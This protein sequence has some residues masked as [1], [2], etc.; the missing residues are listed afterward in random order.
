LRDPSILSGIV[1]LVWGRIHSAGR[2]GHPPQGPLPTSGSSLCLATRRVPLHAP[3]FR[4]GEDLCPMLGFW[5]LRIHRRW[6]ELETCGGTSP[7]HA[8]LSFLCCFFP[9]RCSGSPII[10]NQT[11][12]HSA[13]T[14]RKTIR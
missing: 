8:T 2:S 13:V 11:A 12:N 9:R 5:D 4:N 3:S 14:L 7:G 6:G 10:Q 1:T